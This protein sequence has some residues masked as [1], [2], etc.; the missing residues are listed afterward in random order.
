MSN[1]FKN[2][3]EAL[4]LDYEM[5][6]KPT[7]FSVFTGVS[8]APKDINTLLKDIPCQAACPAKTNVPAYIQAIA[9]GNPEE[10]YRINL[11][12]NV[13][14]GALGRVCTRPCEDQCRHKWTNINGPVSICHLKRAGA[15]HTEQDLAP[16]PA[17]FETSGKRVAIVGGGPAGLTAARELKRYGHEVTLLER[18][19]YLGGMMT[20]GIPSFRLPR[21][22]IDRDVKV[23]VDS[24]ITVEY[25]VDVDAA[26]M[27]ELAE[28]YDAVLVAA[29]AMHPSDLSLP[30][31]DDGMEVAG[32]EFMRRYNFGEI[33]SMT[34]QNI[35]IVGGGFTAVDCARACA[36]AAR[37]LVG[38]EGEVSIMYRRTEGQ[39][40]ANMD[41]IEAMREE[42]I[43]V[44][45]LVSPVSARIEDGHL[46]AVTFH[47]NMLGEVAP[48][49]SKPPITPIENSNF[50]VKADLVIVAIGQVRQLEIMPGDMRATEGHHTR[51]HNVF[52][53]GDFKDGG[54][55]VIT[56]VND[57]KEAADAIDL[58]LTG[59]QRRKTHVAIDL[60]TTNG[61]TGRVRDHDLQKGAPNPV[62]PMSERD[63]SAEVELGFDEASTGVHATRC[64]LCHY[65]FEINQD[66]CIHCDWC[67]KVA[68]RKNCIKKIS[69]LFHDE[70]GNVK[71]DMETSRSADATYIWIDSDECI[72]CGNCLRRCPTD[73]ITLR[74]ISLNTTTISEFDL[75]KKSN[76]VEEPAVVD[77]G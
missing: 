66:K 10:A 17:W 1:P 29:G 25:G 57:A 2:A 24:G 48:G 52:V 35:V 47:R 38:A 21:E 32:L 61:E 60:V 34:G 56:A 43:R 54:V 72:R 23:I 73:A 65:K 71:N 31:L 69:R 6:P 59:A 41:E 4:K 28:T 7:E 63:D 30:G 50:E 5:G 12:D 3:V 64:Y 45:T 8:D 76:V 33:S 62:L 42:N 40:S 26:K 74:K 19:S 11:E 36:R 68:P 18:E 55:D 13:F 9:E 75:L 70:T 15:D 37:R 27:A 39:M 20:M 58:F 77:L 53:A 16:L 49:H 67:I 51:T 46:K 14:P 44:D 22:V